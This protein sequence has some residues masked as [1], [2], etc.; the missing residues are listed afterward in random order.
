MTAGAT[1]NP[2]LIREVIVSGPV[3]L[4]QT[5]TFVRVSFTVGGLT[6]GL[7]MTPDAF[8]SLMVQAL[9]DRDRVLH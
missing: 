2:F 9:L 3:K 6:A 4:V 7:L 5:T 8:A 1:I